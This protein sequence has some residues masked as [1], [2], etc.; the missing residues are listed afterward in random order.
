[1]AALA[2]GYASSG[3]EAGFWGSIIL[4]SWPVDIFISLLKRIACFKRNS[5]LV[6]LEGSYSLYSSLATLQ[7]ASFGSSAF[8]HLSG[9]HFLNKLHVIAAILFVAALIGHAACAHRFSTEGRRTIRVGLKGALG[10]ATESRDL[11]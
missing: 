1:L 3:G 8:S 10:G 11:R 6:F 9:Q 2:T 7:S 5:F 4:T